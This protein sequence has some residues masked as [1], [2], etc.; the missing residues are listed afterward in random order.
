M[1]FLFLFCFFSKNTKNP[2]SLLF[3]ISLSKKALN[4]LLQI[5]KILMM[6]MMMKLLLLLWHQ[7]RNTQ[8]V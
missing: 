3:Y 2:P 7:G 5:S 4:R 8:R 6:M 1:L